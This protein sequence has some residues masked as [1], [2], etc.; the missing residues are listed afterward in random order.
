MVSFTFV[1]SMRRTNLELYMVKGDRGMCHLLIKV[2][3]RPTQTPLCGFAIV[4]HEPLK[5]CSDEHM[6]ERFSFFV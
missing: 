1:S 3:D 5:F 6:F 2:I 4:A